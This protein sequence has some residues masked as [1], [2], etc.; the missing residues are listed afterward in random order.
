[1]L[2]S[3]VVGTYNQQ[4][5][6]RRAIDSALSQSYAEP[7]EVIAVDDCS[8]DGTH[9]TLLSYGGRVR[10]I[11]NEI[12]RGVVWGRNA[13]SA[14]AQ[15][16]YIVYLDG[17]DALLPWALETYARIIELEQPVL[18]IAALQWFDCTVPPQVRES[19]ASGTRYVTYEALAN[20]DRTQGGGASAIVA[21]RE[22]FVRSGG[23]RADLWPLEVD[24]FCLRLAD[25]KTVQILSP[26]T[27]GY[28]MHCSN[29]L[30]NVRLFAEKMFAIMKCERAGD[31]PGGKDL[32]QGLKAFVGGR[33]FYWI[34]LSLK[35]RHFGVAARLIGS[36]WMLIAVAI[37]RRLLVRVHGLKP[38]T[39][40]SLGAATCGGRA[41][42]AIRGR[43]RSWI[44]R[45]WQVAHSSA[46]KNHV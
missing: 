6:V 36:G 43:Y 2:F 15:G 39:V 1:M 20:K 46:A 3:I 9:Q 24:D 19:Y 45:A 32:A 21:S 16:E 4:D 28:V 26:P 35:H 27:S 11:R 23:W 18:L 38:E 17:D 34:R 37:W 12:N 33:T 10:A 8:T 42:A 22:G 5:L 25:S 7:F 41:R 31:Y 29:T 40:L 30:A 14:T 13:A 44:G